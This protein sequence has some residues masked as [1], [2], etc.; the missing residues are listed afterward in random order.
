VFYGLKTDGI[1]QNQAEIDALNTDTNDD[2]V[3]DN[4]DAKFQAGAEPGD[5]RF[6]DVDGDGVFDS[7]VDK[8]V[9]G[10]P[11]PDA[12]MGFNLNLNYKG[13]DFATSLY[14]SIGNDVV[15]SYERFLTYSNKSR[16]YLDRW[17]GEGTSNTVPRASTNSS[18]NVL[19]S[20]FYVEDGSYLRIQNVQLGYSLPSSALE[21]IGFDKLRLYV[22]VNNLH[23]FT[24]YS[25]YNPDVSNASPLGA[26]VDLGQYPQTRTF[27]MGVN[28]SF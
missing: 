10:N 9:I 15:R 17:T 22:A 24:N 25:G 12:T 14:A 2:G 1:Y 3:V 8:T 21:K 26:G 11:I 13:F 28:I 5:L 16:L 23:T 18:G 20:D 4:A 7:T 6:V 19:F 27:T